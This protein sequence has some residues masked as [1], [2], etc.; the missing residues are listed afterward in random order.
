MPLIPVTIQANKTGDS[1]SD[2]NW[3]SLRRIWE[4][5]AKIANGS[6]SFGNGSQSDNIA[7]K[8]VT[9]VTPGAPNTDFVVVHNLGYTA[10]G[11]IPMTKSAACDVYTSPT[12]NPNP[13]TEIILRA[14]VAG[15]TI[16]FFV[17]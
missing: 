8:W 9:A 6:L 2:T 7:G 10:S 5:M 4:Q 13:T 12:V 11:Y 17:L 1:T 3:L 15:V 16:N 14:T